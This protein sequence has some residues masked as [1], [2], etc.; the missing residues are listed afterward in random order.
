MAAETNE[1]DVTHTQSYSI[2][3]KVSHLIRAAQ[4]H[5]SIA[6]SAGNYKMRAGH[7]S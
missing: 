4:L 2:Q 1:M 6:K 7:Y 5:A 3:M